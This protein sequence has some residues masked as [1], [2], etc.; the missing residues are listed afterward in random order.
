MSPPDRDAP[1]RTP[2]PKNED[3]AGDTF[4][5]DATEDWGAFAGLPGHPLMWV[6]IVS[7]LLVFGAALLA[8]AG[9]RIANPVEFLQSQ[10]QLNRLAGAINT[11][12]L[13]TSGLFAAQAVHSTSI[14]AIR[15]RLTL[16]I[17]LGFVFLGVKSVEYTQEIV[18]GY[19]ILT[20]NFFTLFYLIT[21][22]HALHVVLGIIILVIVAVYAS[23]A[24]VET[25]TVFWHM[26]DL[27]WLLIFPVLYLIR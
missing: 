11:M 27:V 22:F 1:L 14:K 5:V 3:A 2:T 8:F 9:I 23:R 4:A 21:G 12:V 17:M 18:A 16:A 20:N 13:L 10:D 15:V 6:L 7:E 26:A 19:D 24:N 25:G